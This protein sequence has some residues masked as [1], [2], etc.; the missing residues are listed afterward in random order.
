VRSAMTGF[1]HRPLALALANIVTI[2]TLLWI[3]AASAI[4]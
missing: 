1:A 2:A 4:A 3:D